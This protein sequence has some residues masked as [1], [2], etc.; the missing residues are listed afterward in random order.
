LRFV[1]QGGWKL[2]HDSAMT[3]IS[4]VRSGH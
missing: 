1:D 4:A 2:S 3:L